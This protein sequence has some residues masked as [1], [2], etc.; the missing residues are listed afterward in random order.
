MFVW[1]GSGAHLTLGEFVQ[2]ELDA[3][4]VAFAERL[5]GD[6]VVADLLDLLAHR[7]FASASSS[8]RALALAPAEEQRSPRSTER[9][10]NW[11]DGGA[12][13]AGW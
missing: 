5:L 10:G 7:V 13:A 3:R 4:E 9:G 2:R 11:L 6:L 8:A 12:R 1:S